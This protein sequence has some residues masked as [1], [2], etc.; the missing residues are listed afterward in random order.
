[1]KATILNGAHANGDPV[2][3]LEGPLHQVLAAQG[4]QIEGFKLRDIPIAYCQGCFECWVKTPGLC[5]IKDDE[6]AIA[7]AM[8]QSE[9][10]VF[11]T[12]LTFGGYSSQLKKAV[13]RLIGLI[14][15]FF[16]RIDGE[17]HHRAR[18]E[19]YPALLGVG[20]LPKADAEQAAIFTS[21]V[22]R[23]AINF[24]APAQASAVFHPGQATSGI[25]ATL[26][27]LIDKLEITA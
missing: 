24:H 11:L 4:Y 26:Q 16:K 20:W 23:N 18:Y 1:M 2:E 25:L 7:E 6:Q 5:K 8:I 10:T 9:L 14:S 22:E 3:K 15:P 21:L 13:D 12:P 19:H 17:I 27:T